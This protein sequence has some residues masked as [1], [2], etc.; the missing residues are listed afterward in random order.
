[1]LKIQDINLREFKADFGKETF[2]PEEVKNLLADQKAQITSNISKEA[3]PILEQVDIL[4]KNNKALEETYAKSRDELKA[5]YS[6]KDEL[7]EKL[8]PFIVMETTKK[9]EE[10]IGNK[11]IKGSE[12]DVYTSPKIQNFIKEQNWSDETPVEEQ[13]KGLGIAVE[14][15]LKEKSY[16]KPIGTPPPALHEDNSVD[17]NGKNNTVDINKYIEDK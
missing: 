6:V 5:L 14:E 4:N 15:Y 12:Y 13:K 17:Q 2:T 1:M 3:N 10:L 9:A 11:V 7:D 8:K 16:L